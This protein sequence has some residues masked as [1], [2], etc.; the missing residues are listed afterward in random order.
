MFTGATVAF[1]VIMDERH[2]YTPPSGVKLGFFLPCL[3]EARSIGG[4]VASLRERFPDAIVVVIDDG[5]SDP[6]AAVARE[7]GARVARLWT[8]MG[9]ATA[10]FA[11]LACCR[12]LGCERIV[13]LDGDGQHSPDDVERLLNSSAADLVVGSRFL[14]GGRYTSTMRAIGINLLR[15]IFRIL[16]G[17]R[18]TDPTSGFR[19]YTGR[20]ADWLLEHQ[21]PS[22]YPE[23]EELAAA[24]QSRRFVVAEVDVSSHIRK[25]GVSS[26]DSIRSA[27]FMLKVSS[28]L[29]L[30]RVLLL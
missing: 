27:Y 12:A 24:I 28:A 19:A 25:E 3:N 5:S 7:A 14:S 6:T 29:L 8:N 17:H 4:I 11:G 15:A 21:Y 9:I 13:R 23:P 20:F 16:H 30:R 10:S 26:I 22:D 1:L 2:T 18:V